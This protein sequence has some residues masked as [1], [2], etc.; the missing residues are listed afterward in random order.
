MPIPTRPY[1]VNTIVL[2]ANTA[3]T[4]T[5]PINASF[6]M[7]GKTPVSEVWLR[8]DGVAAA[9]PAATL[10]DGTGAVHLPMYLDLTG[11]VG[12]SIITSAAN[13]IVSAAFYNYFGINA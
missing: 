8:T 9:V 10:N 11:V 6:V 2:A 13:V 7:F 12:L 4:I 5:I 3:A 1:H